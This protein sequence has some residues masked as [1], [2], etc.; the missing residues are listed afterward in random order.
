[1]RQSTEAEIAAIALPAVA[2]E[3]DDEDIRNFDKYF[4]FHR[5]DTSF[6]EAYA[7]VTEC[8]ALGSGI[9]IYRGADPAAVG[10]ASAQYGLLPGAIGGAIAGVFIDAV[11]G[12]AERR[13]LQRENI[14]MCMSFKGYDRYGLRKNLW[15]EFNFAE[16]NGRC[17]G[18]GATARATDAGAYCVGPAP[19]G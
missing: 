12:S 17:G 9:S 19:A 4:F 2:F 6:S 7:D 1:M 16:G 10:A 13:K 18:T 8:D 14:R 5:P 11:F 3:A 15:E